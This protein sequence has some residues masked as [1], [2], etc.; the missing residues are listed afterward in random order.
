MSEEE[1]VSPLRSYLKR[2]MGGIGP[3]IGFWTHWTRTKGMKWPQDFQY[4]MQPDPPFSLEM[5]LEPDWWDRHWPTRM[6]DVGSGPYPRVGIASSRGRIDLHAC[7]PL[8]PLYRG[9]YEKFDV[10]PYVVPEFAFAEA[11]TDRY[12]PGS[13][14]LVHMSNALD[15]SCMPVAGLMSMLAV[16]K[17]GGLVLL[18]HSENE[19]V[20]ERYRAFHQWNITERDGRMIIWRE[21]ETIDVNELVRDY[22]EVS[23]RRHGSRDPDIIL[24]RMLRNDTPMPATNPFKNRFDAEM[25]ME[26][27]A[28]HRSLEEAQAASAAPENAN[29]PAGPS[30]AS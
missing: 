20:R 28:L 27:H 19:A 5:H 3:E 6:L 12:P 26:L 9:I 30:V 1:A 4:R 22:A 11:L 23:V 15:H 14:D 21:G 8:A 17:P 24:T 7:D 16:A 2:W 18:A 25:L 10:K 29:G 13:F